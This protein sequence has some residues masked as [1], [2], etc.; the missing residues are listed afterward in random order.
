MLLIEL[1]IE[2]CNLL[3]LNERCIRFCKLP[4]SS[5]MPFES[6]FIERS[7]CIMAFR[8]PIS[9][10]KEPV[11]LFEDKSR[12]RRFL[13]FPKLAGMFECTLLVPWNISRREVKFPKQL[14]RD[15]ESW[16]WSKCIYPR[17]YN[18]HWLSPINPESLLPLNLRLWRSLKLLIVV[19]IDPT[20]PFPERL[21]SIKV[22]KFPIPFRIFPLSPHSTT[23]NFTREI[24]PTEIG[25]TTFS[26][27]NDTSR[28]V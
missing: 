23:I 15:P 21:R 9:R 12:F 24:F 8:L 25:S 4:I 22:L 18:L 3:S 1:G 26:G 19:G 27:F 16:F 2:P 17:F 7:I 28:K 6:L 14:G 11:K 13:T 5:G 20:K 10:G